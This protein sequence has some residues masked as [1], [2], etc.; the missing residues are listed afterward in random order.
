[1]TGPTLKNSAA[2]V[3]PSGSTN[4]RACPGRPAGRALSHP[5]GELVYV[6][7]VHQVKDGKI[8][9]LGNTTDAK[10]QLT[11]GGDPITR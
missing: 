7:V 4:F 6:E 10:P 11:P 3:A 9:L 8:Q 2:T 5:A 1:V